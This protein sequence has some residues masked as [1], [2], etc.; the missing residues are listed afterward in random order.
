MYLS[1]FCGHTFSNIYL[2]ALVKNYVERLRPEEGGEHHFLSFNISDRAAADKQ[3]EKTDQN[4]T[5][6]SRDIAIL[7]A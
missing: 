1:P 3:V 4:T 2:S 6:H 5:L 7:R